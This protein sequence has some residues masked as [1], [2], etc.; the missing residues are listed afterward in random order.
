M[1]VEAQHLRVDD[2]IVAPAGYRP[3]RGRRII[4]A[5]KRYPPPPGP[6]ERRFWIEH[7]D[8][9]LVQCEVSLLHANAVVELADEISEQ[10]LTMRMLSS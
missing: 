4:T 2:V 1:N 5:T 9:T 6:E 10:E 3:V 7:I 8:E